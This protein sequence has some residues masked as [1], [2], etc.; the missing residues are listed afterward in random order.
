[1]SDYLPTT[2]TIREN[3]GNSSAASR[4]AFDRW[5]T[6]HDREVARKVWEERGRLDIAAVE[7]WSPDPRAAVAAITDVNW[8]DFDAA[9][10]AVASAICS[11]ASPDMNRT[12]HIPRRIR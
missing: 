8:R 1:V 6:D 10:S 4:A 3:Y 5:L 2:E 9:L 12:I 7:K 11:C